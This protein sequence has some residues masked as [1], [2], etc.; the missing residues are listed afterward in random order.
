MERRELVRAVGGGGLSI[1]AAGCLGQI[2][3]EASEALATDTPTRTPTPQPTATPTPTQPPTQTQSPTPKPTPK[4]TWYESKLGEGAYALTAEV[5]LNGSSKVTFRTMTGVKLATVT[6]NGRTQV[7]GPDGKVPALKPT[8]SIQALRGG[9]NGDQVA[10]H[11]V[12]SGGSGAAISRP[13]H[14]QGLQGATFPDL[15]DSKTIEREL[16]QTIDGARTRFR[17][18]IPEAL[19]A[20]YERRQRTGDYGTYVSDRFD[21]EYVGSLADEIERYGK[22][23]GLSGPAIV[24]ATVA[25]VQGMK[26]TKDS[27]TTAYDEYPRYPIETLYKRGG[28]CEDTSILMAQLLRQLG[29]GVVLFVLP[30]HMGLGVLGDESIPGSYVTHEGKRYYYLETT[31]EGWQI[32][33]LPSAHEKNRSE[34]E[35][36]EIDSQPSLVFSYGVGVPPSGGA[37]VA[38]IVENAGKAAARKASAIFEFQIPGGETVARKKVNFPDL[39]PGQRVNKR[40]SLSPPADEKLRA[41]VRVGIAGTLHDKLVSDYQKPN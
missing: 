35:I 41:R 40:F 12:G 8:A 11:V 31:G 5:Q 32:G 3:S 23:Q 17:Y 37:D 36:V 24:D 25:V 4:I 33:E 9:T 19:F 10:F 28:D 6:S 29:Y 7:A 13:T 2:R 30:G 14:L 27:V 22:Q 34:V 39:G 15:G 21:D 16:T 38:L 20:Y 26:Y 18:Q 1:L